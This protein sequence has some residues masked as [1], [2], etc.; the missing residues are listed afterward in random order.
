MR[1]SGWRLDGSSL[2]GLVSV[3]GDGPSPPGLPSA[4]P[5]GPPWSW[6]LGLL[7]SCRRESKEERRSLPVV[8]WGA[9]AASCTRAG[10][11]A[12]GIR[13]LVELAESASQPDVISYNAVASAGDVGWRQVL[14]L[15]GQ[16]PLFGLEP[17]LTSWS[18]LTASC[19]RASCWEQCILVL[20][21]LSSTGLRPDPVVLCSVLGS[22]RG[23]WEMSLQL[24]NKASQQVPDGVLLSAAARACADGR[25]WQHSLQ[26]LAAM[27]CTDS[28]WL[29]PGV[30]NA[31]L[32]ACLAGHRWQ[33]VLARRSEPDALGCSAA[34]TTCGASGR[35]EMALALAHWL[36]SRS[37][38]AM[39]QTASGATVWGSLA[40]ALGCEQ[41]HWAL[42][43]LSA[44]EG[45]GTRPPLLAQCAVASAAAARGGFG[46]LPGL[47]EAAQGRAAEA[48]VGGLLSGT[49]KTRGSMDFE[50]SSGY[51]REQKAE[52]FC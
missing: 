3:S 18:V 24:L 43:C 41:W 23:S 52:E 45:L 30:Q 16:L 14:S 20:D 44:V 22:Y 32:G 46:P 36:S 38:S 21:A 29:D 34:A 7:Q 51:G 17:D 50:K 2:A 11:W 9:V 26:L 1:Q 31:A 25:S 40:L 35:W 12:W 6:S 5:R 27:P 8:T 33:L 13:L 4:R 49:L 48:R 47:S 10:Q 39:R 28:M 19:G 15:L 37:V 42:R